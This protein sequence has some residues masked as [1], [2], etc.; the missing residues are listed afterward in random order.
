VTLTQ[1]G[2]VNLDFPFIDGITNLVKE[3]YEEHQEK[4]QD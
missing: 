2:A 4:Y 3:D 1:E